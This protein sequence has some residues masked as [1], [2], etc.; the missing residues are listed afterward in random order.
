MVCSTVAN[1]TPVEAFSWTEKVTQGVGQKSD[2]P[3]SLGCFGRQ[4]WPVPAF[5]QVAVRQ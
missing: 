2:V 5:P 4:F 1:D 3:Q